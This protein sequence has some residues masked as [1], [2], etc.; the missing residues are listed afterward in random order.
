MLWFIHRVSVC[1]FGDWFFRP[2]APNLCANLPSLLPKFQLLMCVR[3]KR[4]RS[5][6]GSNFTHQRHMK[7]TPP[8]ITSI[9]EA[10][11][12][13]AFYGARV[14]RRR[15]GSGMIDGSTALLRNTSSNDRS[16]YYGHSAAESKVRLLL[17]KP[18]SKQQAA[19]SQATQLKSLPLDLLLLNPLLNRLLELFLILSLQSLLHWAILAQATINLRS[20]TLLLQL[21]LMSVLPLS[22]DESVL[23]GFARCH[24]GLTAS[25]WQ[26]SCS[27]M[28]ITD[29]QAMT[30]STRWKSRCVGHSGIFGMRSLVERTMSAVI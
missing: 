10:S 2:A 8:L 26:P 20:I 7:R 18:L 5:P 22:L 28:A 19:I 21:L 15:Q 6:A 27:M 13:K 25:K 29:F 12:L 1:F 4:W 14:H 16:H 9:R 17:R 23:G 30:T 3:G 11:L 24:F